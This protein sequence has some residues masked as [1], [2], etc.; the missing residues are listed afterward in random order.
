MRK[1]GE[2]GESGY[3]ELEVWK[4]GEEMWIRGASLS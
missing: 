2:E 1:G 3:Q 4:E